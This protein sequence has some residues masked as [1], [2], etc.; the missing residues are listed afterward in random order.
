M[1][2]G[3]VITLACFQLEFKA[4]Q[5]FHVTVAPGVLFFNRENWDYRPVSNLNLFK[6]LD[7]YAFEQTLFLRIYSI[8]VIVAKESIL[9]HT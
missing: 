1:C 9:N 5:P 2:R 8:I 4:L 7:I 3:S 6:G